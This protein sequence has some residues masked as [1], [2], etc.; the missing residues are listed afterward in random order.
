[1]VVIS[2]HLIVLPM[3]FTINLRQ[4]KINMKLSVLFP[5]VHC[6]YKQMDDI[7]QKTCIQQKGDSM[8]HSC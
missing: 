3:Y 5:K 8:Y 1:M 2:N 6:H 4:D 7:L